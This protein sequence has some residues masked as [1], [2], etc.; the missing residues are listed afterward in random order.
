M[1]QV[2]NTKCSNVLCCKAKYLLK[3]G[4]TLYITVLFEKST[5]ESTEPPKKQQVNNINERVDFNI[6]QKASS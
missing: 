3:A 1:L 4:S 2:W 5:K 6:L